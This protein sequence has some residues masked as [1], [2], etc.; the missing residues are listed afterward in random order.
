MLGCASRQQDFSKEAIMKSYLSQ[1][2]K[3]DGIDRQEAVILGQSQIVFRGY[4]QEYLLGNP[5]F[6]K[7]SDRQYV[8]KFYPKIKTFAERRGYPPILVWVEKNDGQTRLR[9]LN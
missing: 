9:W 6:I 8:L 3:S 1:V 7:E 2:K 5:E 4:D